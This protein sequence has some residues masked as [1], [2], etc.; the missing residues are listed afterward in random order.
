VLRLCLRRTDSDPTPAETSFLVRSAQTQPRGPRKNPPHSSPHLN[1]LVAPRESATR[2]IQRA[3]N[4]N[5]PL[6]LPYLLL[7][8]PTGK[9]CFHS[10]NPACCFALAAPSLL[11]RHSFIIS[12]Q[13]ETTATGAAA[14]A[15]IL[16]IPIPYHT[17][18]LHHNVPWC[19]CFLSYPLPTHLPTFRELLPNLPTLPYSKWYLTAVALQYLHPPSGTASTRS[20]RSLLHSSH[21]SRHTSSGSNAAHCFRYQSELGNLVPRSSHEHAPSRS[22]PV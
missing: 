20:T 13:Q 14:A 17:L 18:Y 9:Y 3:G 11:A 7:T 4:R 1:T 2:E 16:T 22:H 6:S 19:A 5:R 12:C 8:I 21:S 10:Q 15:S